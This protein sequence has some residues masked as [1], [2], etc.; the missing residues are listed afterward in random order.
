MNRWHMTFKMKFTRVDLT[1]EIEI[2]AIGYN[3]HSTNFTCWEFS[4][5]YSC[6]SQ[7]LKK[8]L[9]II[10]HILYKKRYS[11]QNW[12]TKKHALM[13][14][15]TISKT[16]NVLKL[17]QVKLYWFNDSSAW[18]SHYG[19]VFWLWIILN[20]RSRFRL[21]WWC[22]MSVRIRFSAGGEVTSQPVR[23]EG[24]MCL[25]LRRRIFPSSVA[26]R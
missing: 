25:L 9:L 10:L 1:Y 3:I 7:K 5:T 8:T 19:T 20:V 14:I 18:S 15:L 12:G 4:K 11:K 16:C 23:C 17:L 13:T 21:Y 26:T 22:G 6:I 2:P 24:M